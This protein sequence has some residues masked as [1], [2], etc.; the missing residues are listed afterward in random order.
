MICG[1]QPA[2]VPNGWEAVGLPVCYVP[3]QPGISK[4]DALGREDEATN[5]TGREP[6]P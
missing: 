4:E 3:M 6:A 2:A 5:G 1:Q